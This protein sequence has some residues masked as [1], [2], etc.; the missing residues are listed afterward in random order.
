M[1]IIATSA[2]ETP[3]AP[4]RPPAEDGSDVQ[5]FLGCRVGIGEGSIGEDD[6]GQLLEREMI[7]YDDLN[8]S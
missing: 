2:T 4:R 8:A 6:D 1:A 7:R 3:V 5:P